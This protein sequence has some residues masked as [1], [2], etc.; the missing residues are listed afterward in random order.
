MLGIQVVHRSTSSTRNR[1]GGGTT[2]Y[3]PLPRINEGMV[4][5]VSLFASLDLTLM[6]ITCSSGAAD[7][8]VGVRANDYSTPHNLT[9][10]LTPQKAEAWNT[11][12]VDDRKTKTMP[13]NLEV[14]TNTMLTGQLGHREEADVIRHSSY[15]HSGARLLVPHVPYQAGERQRR[16]VCL[17]H[18]QALQHYLC[19]GAVRPP[20]EE[21]E[22]LYKQSKVDIVRHRCRANLVAHTTATGH[23]INTH[24][25]REKAHTRGV[26]DGQGWCVGHEIKKGLI[27][28]WNSLLCKLKINHTSCGKMTRIYYTRSFPWIENNTQG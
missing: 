24:A 4:A 6:L 28:V 15:E 10:T 1:R 2:T 3:C 9:R 27:K 13:K 20:G 23:Q 5:F 7:C 22:Q 17:G 25:E 16:A 11:I 21:P 19:E 8:S 14:T 18:V 26:W 12:Q